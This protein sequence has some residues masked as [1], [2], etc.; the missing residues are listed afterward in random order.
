[1]GKTTLRASINRG[2]APGGDLHR[3][4]RELGQY[5]VATRDDAEAL[6]EALIRFP[7]T[8][9]K[10]PLHAGREILAKHNPGSF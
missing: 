9:Q 10:S 1:M 3:E 4:L 2:L 7:Q 5:R 8:Q 6:C